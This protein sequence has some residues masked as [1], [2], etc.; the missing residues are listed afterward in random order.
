MAQVFY[1]KYSKR[2]RE[3]IVRYL[4][5]EDRFHVKIFKDCTISD[6]SDV[7]RAY[8]R[9]YGWTFLSYETVDY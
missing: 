7:F 2:Y 4:D 3:V 8:A 9:V 1:R 5:F 6:A